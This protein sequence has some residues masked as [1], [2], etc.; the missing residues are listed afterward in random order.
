MQNT[1]RWMSTLAA[2]AAGVLLTAG[3]AH[4]LTLEQA[5]Q[6]ALRNDPNF[7]ASY[8]AGEAGKENRILGRSSLLPTVSGSYSANKNNTDLLSGRS[9]THP[10]YTSRAAN[11]QLRQAIFNLDA[12]A[13]YRQGVAQANAS[14][15]S[16]EAARQE[17]IVR[18]VSAYIEALFSNEQ[19][20]LIKAQRD[21]LAEQK[22]VNDRLYKG[23]EGTVTDQLETQAKL[24]LAEA[25][26]LEAMDAQRAA[27]VT[28]QGIVG[29]E[30]T[31]LDQLR[32]DFSVRQVDMRSFEEWR[33][34]A[35]ETNPALRA[36]AY[37]V[38]VQRQ[39]VNK[40]K[41]GH[42]PRLDF[43]ATYAKNDSETLN[44]LNQES[45][46]RSLGVQLNIPFY[47]GGAVNAATRQA[48]AN[49]ERAKA[50][51]QARSDK[52]TVDLRKEYDAVISGVTKM[53]AL[54]KA[55]ESANLLVKATTQS[56]KGGVR[57]NLDLLNAQENKFQAQRD[58]AQARFTYL[59]GTLRLRAAAG[60]LSE[61]D[62]KEVSAYFR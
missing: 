60:T 37:G 35:L 19:L 25:Q 33:R 46:Q 22:V 8:Y 44:T 55:V 20:A 17:L 12:L 16:V 26:L 3:A 11:V 14:E 38:E 57:I 7:K 59:L 31:A 9:L 21:M 45:T 13:R 56:I 52:V 50:E 49:E 34:T 42:Y 47:Q 28:L 53:K 29:E 54:E 41:A 24:D 18:V 27:L 43:V 5:F 48:R 40:A 61:R 1:R 10:R 58:L 4:A 51:L 23:G 36:A 2:A 32:P 30:V 15:A 39:E 62:V 6:A